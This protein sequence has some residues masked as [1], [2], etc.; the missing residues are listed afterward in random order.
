[1]ATTRRLA[2]AGAAGVGLGAIR[3][4]VPPLNR[5]N[6]SLCMIRRVAGSVS[7]PVLSAGECASG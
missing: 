4:L 7:R 1:M 6:V 3:G 2:G 5:S